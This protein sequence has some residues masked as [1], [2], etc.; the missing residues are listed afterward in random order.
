[1]VSVPVS[2][3]AVLVMI[4][5]FAWMVLY[6]H[7]TRVASEA[8]PHP[9]IISSSDDDDWEGE[10]DDLYLPLHG[11]PSA[12]H[13]LALPLPLS[14]QGGQPSSGGAEPRPEPEPGSTVSDSVS[15]W[16][17]SK[18]KLKKLDSTDPISSGAD[19]Q[20][21]TVDPTLPSSDTSTTPVVRQEVIT[22]LAPV[23]TKELGTP[24][25]PS[26]WSPDAAVAEQQQQQQQQQ[27]RGRGREA[28]DAEAEGELSEQA[29]AQMLQ[30]LN[31][32]GDG[33]DSG[34][35]A[36]AEP[37]STPS[38]IEEPQLTMHAARALVIADTA[39]ADLMGL[40]PP[41]RQKP[42]LA[43]REEDPAAA[44]SPTQAMADQAKVSVAGCVYSCG[45]LCRLRRS[46]AGWLAGWVYCS[47]PCRILS[48]QGPGGAMRWWHWHGAAG[49]GL[50]GERGDGE[51]PTRRDE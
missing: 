41:R 17:A 31:G 3:V 47:M 12:S 38:P 46:V 26:L 39:D 49:R 19:R 35:T 5:C 1:M 8:T 14:A 42:P 24:P 18:E 40:T 45:S 29:L 36:A 6:D 15:A 34:A 21:L 20:Q 13:R 27:G 51:T 10:T 7:M 2:V 16:R 25:T 30:S 9:S 22:H 23:E 43:E 4:I 37:A 50:P 44:A 11:N 33:D 28:A 48:S 32:E